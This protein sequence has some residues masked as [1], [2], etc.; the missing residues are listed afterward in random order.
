MQSVTN[1]ERSLLVQV[2]SLDDVIRIKKD[3]VSVSML[4]NES[5]ALADAFVAANFAYVCDIIG[6]ELSNAQKIDLLDEI[7]QVGWLTMPDVKV[8]LDRM[9]K[10]KFYR[11]DY[12][13]LINEFWKYVDDRLEMGAMLANQNT[14]HTDNYPRSN[15]IN[16]IQQVKIFEINQGR[17]NNH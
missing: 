9:K 1:E 7:G 6:I 15:K 17:K 10:H 12:Q 5:P 4:R 13:E 3:Y 2:K 14:D 16:H 11:K 8:F